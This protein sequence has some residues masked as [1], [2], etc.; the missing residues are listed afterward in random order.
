MHLL[1]SSQSQKTV[2]AATCQRL[3]KHHSEAFAI[4]SPQSVSQNDLRAK[5]VTDTCLWGGTTDILF[6]V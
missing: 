6:Y 3:Q 1:S 5:H 2:I 4:S